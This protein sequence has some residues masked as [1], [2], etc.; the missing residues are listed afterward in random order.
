MIAVV[1]SLRCEYCRTPAVFRKS[2][3]HIY[4][5]RDYG[6]IWECGG[7]CDAY[8]GT[9]PDGSPVGRL[10]NKA[11]RQLKMKVHARFDHLWQDFRT[12]YPDANRSSGKMKKAMRGRAYAWLAEQMQIEI[13]ECHVGKFDD[14]Q[15]E[16]AIRILDELN[17]T[18]ATVRAWAKTV[19][20]AR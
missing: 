9:H 10:A 13:D 18:A 7:G 17:P 12:A 5:G 15:C 2:S 3:A 8:V 4:K 19:V 6:P 16:Q 1:V 14:A 20:S 11:L